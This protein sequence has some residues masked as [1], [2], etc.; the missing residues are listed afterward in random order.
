MITPNSCIEYVKTVN[1][2]NNVHKIIERLI[3]RQYLLDIYVRETRKLFDLHNRKW[4]KQCKIVLSKTYTNK[5]GP[6]K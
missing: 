2:D 5:M 1:V 3:L 6:T 4:L